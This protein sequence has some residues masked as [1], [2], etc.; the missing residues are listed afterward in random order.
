MSAARITRRHI[1]AAL[2]F[3]VFMLAGIAFAATV[4]GGGSSSA[5]AANA[6]AF[7]EKFAAE[8]AQAGS[9]LKVGDVA[10][11]FTL[12]NLEGQA[13]K[14]SDFGG[15]PVLINF[16][17]TWCGP[18]QVE[19]PEI[20]AVYQKYRAQGFTVLAVDVQEPASDVRR[21]AQEK[22]LSFVPLLDSAS[23][24]FKLYQVRALPTSY[25]VDRQ[26]RISALH[27]GAMTGDQITGY[28]TN[29]LAKP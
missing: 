9:L 10:P 8:F 6:P 28:L 4:V 14:L 23:E 11:D 15:K 20:E 26:G 7:G 25:F 21:F 16:W 13:V 12:Q 27:L 29:I 22:Q 17:A 18:C 5:T 2:V 1:A 3:I 24:V 19:M